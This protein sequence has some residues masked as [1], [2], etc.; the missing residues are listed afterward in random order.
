MTD[1]SFF[2]DTHDTEIASCCVWLCVR[3]LGC[4][5]LTA[6]TASKIS[7]FGRSMR[8]RSGHQL[9]PQGVS[10]S[11]IL[12]HLSLEGTRLTRDIWGGGSM[13]WGGQSTSQSTIQ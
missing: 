3:G 11:T 6:R 13:Y 2:S 7:T 8:G 9:S 12:A 4:I 10:C 5:T 1:G